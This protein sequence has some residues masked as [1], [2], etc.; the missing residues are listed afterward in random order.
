[1]SAIFSHIAIEDKN[2][3]G[4]AAITENASAQPAKKTFKLKRH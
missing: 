4:N 3:S 2:A 1:M